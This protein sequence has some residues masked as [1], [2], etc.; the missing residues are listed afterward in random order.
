MLVLRYHN[1]EYILPPEQA[2]Q[3]V[4]INPGTTSTNSSGMLVDAIEYQ[5]L[6]GFLLIVKLERQLY[7]TEDTAMF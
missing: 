7:R 1:L 3:H 2:V 6:T 4:R 5:I